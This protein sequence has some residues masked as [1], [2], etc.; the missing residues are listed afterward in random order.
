LFALSN[1]E[2]LIEPKAKYS[3]KKKSELKEE[4]PNV[5][6]EKLENE[7]HMKL[8]NFEENNKEE[9]PKVHEEENFENEKYRSLVKFEENKEKFIE[10]KKCFNIKYEKNML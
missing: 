2:F 5:A 4:D 3:R 8:V 10:R 6:E 1:P 9:H 7:E